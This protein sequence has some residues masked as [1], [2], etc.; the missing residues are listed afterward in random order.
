MIEPIRLGRWLLFTLFLPFSLTARV[1]ETEA[2]LAREFGEPTARAMENVMVKGKLLPSFVKLTYQQG[3]WHLTCILVDE[4]CAKTIYLR[5]GIWPDEDY[6]RLLAENAQGG[7]WEPDAKG[8]KLPTVKRSWI[9]G[10]GATAV[11]RKNVGLTIVTPAFV[12]AEAAVKDKARNQITI[13][14]KD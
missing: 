2:A 14:P 7:T 11:W 3:D 1:G 8:S 9:R 4:R 5:E 6:A 12:A 10:D 13:L